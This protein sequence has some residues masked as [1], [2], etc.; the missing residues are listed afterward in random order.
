MEGTH[1]HNN[2]SYALLHSAIGNHSYA[3]H[4]LN[5]AAAQTDSINSAEDLA[6][7]KA[8]IELNMGEYDKCIETLTKQTASEQVTTK[9][10]A[11]EYIRHFIS[12]KAYFLNNEN[13]KA[14][15][16][17]YRAKDEAQSSSEN[18]GNWKVEALRNVGILM[19][20]VE[21]ESS[22]QKSVG[23]I[24]DSAYMPKIDRK[25]QVQAPPSQQVQHQPKPVGPAI[26]KKYD[27]YQNNTHLF[28]SF[29]VSSPDV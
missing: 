4:L 12:G 17:L 29:K 11:L 7:G 27:W 24:N 2:L 23:N 10:E 9:S 26:D 8:L 13:D 19:K 16:E 6:I 3:N 28:I 20:K 5:A 22:N 21:L 1:K 14:L 18:S 15:I 25:G